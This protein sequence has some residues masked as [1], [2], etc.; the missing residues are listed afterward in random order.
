MHP[1]PHS[2]KRW[3]LQVLSWKLLEKLHKPTRLA[4]EHHR[5][6]WISSEHQGQRAPAVVWTSVVGALTGHDRS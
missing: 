3:C 5:H 4:L 2:K 1:K 6:H